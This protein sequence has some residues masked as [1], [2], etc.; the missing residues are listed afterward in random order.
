MNSEHL[1][2]I[3]F[4]YGPAGCGKGT[5]AMKLLE[6]YPDYEYIEVGEVLR[7]F[8]KTYKSDSSNPE[9]SQAA[10]NAE[11]NMSQG[12]AVDFTDWKYIWEHTVTPMVQSGKKLLFDGIFRE[13]HQ[14]VFLASFVLDQKSTCALAVIHITVDEAIKRLSTR[15]YVPGNRQPFSSFEEAKKECPAGVEPVSRSDDQDPEVI[16]NRYRNQYELQ[17]GRCISIYQRVTGGDLY[18]I[19]GEQ[20]INEVFIQIN[21]NL[22]NFKNK[23]TRI[24]I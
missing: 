5:Q 23:F 24:T 20:P 2:Q 9:H 22:E 16:R 13:Y 14:S 3:L 21:Q 11:F 12:K 19:D 8:I 17:F 4:L 15:F 7:N 10:S 18:I 6:E 1:P